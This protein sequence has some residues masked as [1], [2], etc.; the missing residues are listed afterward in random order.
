MDMTQAKMT[1]S[2]VCVPRDSISDIGGKH[3]TVSL[4]H[5][6]SLEFQAT[7]V[8]RTLGAFSG[9]DIDCPELEWKERIE[10]FRL[11]QATN[12]WVYVGRQDGDL[13]FKNPN[14]NTFNNWRLFRYQL[15]TDP[16]NS[17]PA[18]LAAQG[19]ERL[20]RRW[21]AEHGFT[22][23]LAITDKPAMGVSGGSGGGAGESL[24][25]GKTR[26]RVIYFDLGFSGTTE[27]VKLVQ[28]LETPSTGC[29]AWV[30]R[31]LWWTT[32]PISIAGASSF[33]R[34]AR[35]IKPS[36]RCYGKHGATAKGWRRALVRSIA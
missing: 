28:I 36:H 33:D 7:V 16:T 30:F 8:P 5:T 18:A 35:G 29:S 3:S 19:D 26:R 31:R 27:R 17:P 13:Y 12:Q 15:A 22:W 34:Q 23:K 4:G 24:V 11:D 2:K 32:P 20:A 1:I 6:F 10:W 21:I 9:E 25:T 14:S